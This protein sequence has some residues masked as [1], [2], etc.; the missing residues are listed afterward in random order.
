MHEPKTLWRIARK[1]ASVSFTPWISA[2]RDAPE[3]IV[4]FDEWLASLPLPGESVC[5]F[6]SGPHDAIEMSWSEA[7]VRLRS[8]FPISSEV[9]VLGEDLRTLITLSSVGVA[10]FTPAYDTDASHEVA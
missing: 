5:Y 6:I 7:S 10:R 3:Y 8:T 1:R 4:R 9:F 2:S